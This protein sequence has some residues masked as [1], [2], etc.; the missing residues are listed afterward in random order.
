MYCGLGLHRIS[1]VHLTNMTKKFSDSSCREKEETTRPA[2]TEPW[3]Q[4]HPTL[5]VLPGTQM[6][7]TCVWSWRNSLES[8]SQII[9]K[10]L[11]AVQ[12]VT[13]E[14]RIIWDSESHFT[15]SST[16]CCVFHIFWWIL[17]FSDILDNLI[18]TEQWSQVLDAL[19]GSTAFN[20]PQFKA[21]LSACG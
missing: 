11:R 17:N 16:C 19:K 7:K 8:S 4:T 13:K 6:P 5:L 3:S 20:F 12:A 15:R 2:C 10:G 18:G 21:P 14:N 1:F 9:Q